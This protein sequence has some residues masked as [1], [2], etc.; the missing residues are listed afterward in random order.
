MHRRGKQIL[1]PPTVVL[2]VR[3]GVDPSAFLAHTT[4]QRKVRS[5]SPAVRAAVWPTSLCASPD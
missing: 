1:G 4:Q 5:F 2:M 3:P